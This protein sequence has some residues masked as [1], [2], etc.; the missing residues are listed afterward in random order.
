M[1]KQSNRF[2]SIAAAVFGG[3][4]GLVF[5]ASSAF[6]ANMLVFGDRPTEQAS[7]T[8]ILTGLGHTVTNSS[9][10]PASF[11]GYNVVWHVRIS[12]A[13][14]PAEEA[15]MSSYIL[16]GGS[17]YFTGER[18]CC[19]AANV[20][21]QDVLRSVVSGGSTI[22]VGNLGDIGGSYTFNPAAPGGIS[23]TP[24]A[25]S[26]WTPSAS[27]GMANIPAANIFATGAGAVTVGAVF[28]PSDM[29]SGVGRA[30]VLMDVNYLL[31]DP[32]LSQI[33][34][35]IALF[36]Q[37]GAPAAAVT[38]PTLSPAMLFLLV[39]LV[40]GAAGWSRRRVS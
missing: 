5:M 31:S 9:A 19:D 36:L 10:M 13:M 23:T 21:I 37:S 25:L 14:S 18:P 38:V 24:N 11:A 35:N 6:A 34:A 2:C 32:A 40:L 15:Q 29:N 1:K 26:A 22:Q 33:I 12:S 4:M 30:V 3:L 8:T 27:G 39:A 28:G 20:S 16:G 17:V 7:L